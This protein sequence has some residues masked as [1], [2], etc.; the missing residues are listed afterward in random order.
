MSI[1]RQPASLCAALAIRDAW[2]IFLATVEDAEQATKDVSENVASNAAEARHEM[3]VS[4]ADA[5]LK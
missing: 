3:T 5:E 1:I 4:L 2:L